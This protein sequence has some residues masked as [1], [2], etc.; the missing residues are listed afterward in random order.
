MVLLAEVWPYI[1][2]CCFKSV[3]VLRMQMMNFFYVKLY[4]S[5]KNRYY[6]RLVKKRTVEIFGY[7]S[8]KAALLKEAAQDNSKLFL[9]PLEIRK[10][11]THW[12]R[13]PLF[14]SPSLAWNCR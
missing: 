3:R 11:E 7:R 9:L 10:H 12:I 13:L 1:L 5:E 6:S 2:Q 14:C 4:Q 8:D